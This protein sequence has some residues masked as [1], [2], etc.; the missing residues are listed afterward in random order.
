MKGIIVSADSVQVYDNVQIGANKPSLETLQDTPHILLNLVD[1]ATPYTY[2]TAEWRRDAIFAIQRLVWGNYCSNNAYLHSNEMESLSE[3]T[4]LEDQQR[5]KC[6]L[7]TIQ[8]AKAMKDSHADQSR[9][10]EN[11]VEKRIRKHHRICRSLWV[12]Q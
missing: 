6:I 4:I 11:G 10:E 9:K 1:H 7:S 2:N 3:Q 5:Q 12:A 8:V